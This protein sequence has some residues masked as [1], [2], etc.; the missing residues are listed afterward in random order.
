MARRGSGV[1]MRLRLLTAFVA[2]V[3]ACCALAVVG[4]AQ[5][6][7]HSRALKVTLRDAGHKVVGTVRMS[8]A[9]PTGAV[10]VRAVVRGLKPGFHGFHV[11]AVGVCDGPAFKSAMGHLKHAGQ[12]HGG[13]DGDLPSLLVKRNGTATLRATTDGFTLD[14]L[15]D[16]DGSAVMVHAGP[17]NYANIPPRY[18]PNGPDQET[19]DTGDSGDRVACGRIAPG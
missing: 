10:E 15:R 13:H 6:S 5:R 17:D 14:D 16:R 9:A 7:N 4:S 19:L 2:A 12:A 1:A 18:A 11:H 8:A 3:A